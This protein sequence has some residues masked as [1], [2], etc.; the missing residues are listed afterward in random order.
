MTLQPGSDTENFGG[1]KRSSDKVPLLNTYWKVVFLHL[2]V[3]NYRH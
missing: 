2:R 3:Q 1:L